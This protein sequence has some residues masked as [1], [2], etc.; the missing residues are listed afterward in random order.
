MKEESWMGPP[1][2]LMAMGCFFL[3]FAKILGPQQL[4]MIQN[5]LLKNAV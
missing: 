2:A 4:M 5:L 3:D 1:V